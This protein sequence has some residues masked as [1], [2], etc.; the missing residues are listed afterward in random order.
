MKRIVVVGAGQAAASLAARLRAL[1]YDG[2]LTLIGAEPDPPYQRPPL[3]KG[4]LL[5]EMARERLWLRKREWYEENGVELRLGGPVTAIDPDVRTVTAGETLPYDALVLATGARPRRLSDAQG[6]RLEGWHTVRTL[7]DIDAIAPEMRAGRHLLVVGG[8]YI[9]LEAA[10]VAR[11]LGLD[12]TVIE[13][14]PRILGR[15]A[16]AETADWFRELHRAN[17]VTLRE[18]VGLDT[19]L[20]EHRVT[21]ARLS[22]G[23]TVEADLVLAGIGVDPHS[24]LAEATGCAQTNGITVDAY[25]RTSVP[26]IWAC[27]DAASVPFRGAHRRLE[28]VQNAIDGAEAV[29]ANLLGAE[30]PY[31]PHPWFWSDQ[32]D[33]HLQIAGLNTGHDRVVVREDGTGRSHWHYAGGTLVS[34]DAIDASRDYMVAKRLLEAGRSPAP[35]AVA[36]TGTPIKAL[37]Q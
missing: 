16:A 21:G 3:S 14:G 32:Y 26:G 8:G 19:L 11:R 33:A 7:S 30:A 10:A 9:G 31:E 2:A 17:G 5:G 12:V 36:D 34:V 22:D 18:G 6:A 20:G 35:D 13:M 24:P 15:V 4:Y 1:G 23:T 29:A 28:N 25:G 37:L 27:G